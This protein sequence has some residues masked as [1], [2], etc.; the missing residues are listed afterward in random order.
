MFLK[1]SK[2]EACNRCC[3]TEQLLHFLN[4]CHSL[5]IT[6]ID[7]KCWS[8]Y[9]VSSVDLELGK[10]YKIKI[11]NGAP[12]S[13]R[14]ASGYPFP[15]AQGYQGRESCV[16]LFASAGFLGKVRIRVLLILPT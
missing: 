15:S 6:F 16:I 10:C 8:L 1:P 14:P 5:S 4:A 2:I 12:V 9:V 3:F 11:C 7:C 13:V